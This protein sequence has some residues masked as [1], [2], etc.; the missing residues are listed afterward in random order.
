[1]WYDYLRV[2]LKDYVTKKIFIIILIYLPALMANETCGIY[3][4]IGTVELKKLNYIIVLNKDTATE[5]NIIVDKD[6]SIKLI[7]Y[8]NKSLKGKCDITHFNQTQM[9]AKEIT[10]LEF[11][12]PNLV[13][14]TKDSLT[15]I[16]S[17]ECEE[18]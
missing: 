12:V 10:S 1:M 5:L 8:L 15:L 14:V 4:F 6:S 9:N 17:K 16:Q 2:A 11:I 13:A 7:P 18:K 3:S